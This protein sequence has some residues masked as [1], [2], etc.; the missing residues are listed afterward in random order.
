MFIGH[1]A[2]AAAAKKAAPKVSLAWL[3]AAAQLVD[4]L[5]PA[6]LLFG[7]E[8]V[9]ID[10]GNT[11]VTPADFYD[12]PITHSL[13]G[14]LGWS[15]LLGGLYYIVKKER[16]DALIIGGLVFSHWILDLLTHRPD[17]PLLGNDSA[18]VGLGLWNSLAGTIIVEFGLFAAGWFL[19]FKS[20]APKNRTGTVAALSLVV[21]LLVMHIGN[22]FG[23]PPPNADMFA[24]AGNA[25]WLFVLW[26]WWIERN[27][28]I[29]E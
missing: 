8:H 7:L 22:I 14:A 17:L 29:V 1:F 19:Y 24:V 5:W 28:K 2:V 27:R 13:I 6:F 20:T 11:V 12:Y 4:L 3:I 23:P 16:R 25:M 10:P 15:V 18:K 21:F 26:G 9:R